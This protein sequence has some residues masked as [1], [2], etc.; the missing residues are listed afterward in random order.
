MQIKSTKTMAK[1]KKYGKRYSRRKLLQRGDIKE[2][3]RLT[4]LAPITITQQLRGDRKLQPL[5]KSLADQFADR[6]EAQMV[7][8]IK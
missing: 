7:Q 6:T 1:S 8:K 5:V 2:I 4:G 3:A